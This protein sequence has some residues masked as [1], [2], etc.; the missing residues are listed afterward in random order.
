[1]YFIGIDVGTTATK[2]SLFSENGQQ[3]FSKSVEYSILSEHPS[4]FEQKTQDWINGVLRALKELC[5]FIV[6]KKISFK[7]IGG[8]GVTGQAPSLVLTDQNGKVLRNAIIWMDG[9][10]ADEAKEIQKEY[11]FPATPSSLS[12]KF[13]WV[14]RNE[15]GTIQ[16][17]R[18]FFEK[19]SDFIVFFL[20]GK[21]VRGKIFKIDEFDLVKEL[22]ETHNLSSI[23]LPEEV[24]SSCFAGTLKPEIRE[25]LG[26]HE[27]I[28]VTA[29]CVDGI[30]SLFGT[31]TVKDYKASVVL[32]TSLTIDVCIPEPVFDD[33]N[34]FFCNYNMISNKWYVAG[35]SNSGGNAYRWFRDVF[36]EIEKSVSAQLGKSAYEILDLEAK[37]I[38]PGSEGLLFLPYLSGER[39]PINDPMA[40]GI[41]FGITLNHRRSHFARAILEGIAFSLYQLISIFEGKGIPVKE[42]ILSGNGARSI[43][44]PQIIANVI[45]KT[46]KIPKVLDT[47]VLGAAIQAAVASKVFKNVSDAADCMVKIEKNIVPDNSLHE[48]Y[49]SLYNIFKELYPRVKDLFCD[50]SKLEKDGK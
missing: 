20:T 12:S 23:K 38:P 22:I 15:K 24:L 13:L 7:D 3:I 33:K 45:G 2:V 40:R 41:F 4:Y 35:I 36:G 14:T 25:I 30:S 8:I 47:T 11:N 9:R 16:S 39:S 27:E 42:A 17:T 1:M 28:P 48:K 26:V 21:Y 29:G 46:V 44:W 49:K 6:K 50:L 10:A 5:N 37:N 19:A 34:R 32:G 18:M 43:I 31:G